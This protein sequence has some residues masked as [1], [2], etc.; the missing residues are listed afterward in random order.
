MRR[1]GLFRDA[2]KALVDRN[3]IREES[4]AGHAKPLHLRQ[5]AS[6]KAY[7]RDG[8]GSSQSSLYRTDY[9][10]YLAMAKTE[11]EA[12][13]NIFRERSILVRG[14]DTTGAKMLC[15]SR[16]D[17]IRHSESWLPVEIQGFRILRSFK[18]LY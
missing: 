5:N 2:I 13:Q 16:L 6:A 10:T 14:C 8:S 7:A 9:R 1:S 15:D 17:E 3:T 18:L 12:L 11:P 4:V